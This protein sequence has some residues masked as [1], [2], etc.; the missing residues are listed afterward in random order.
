MEKKINGTS[1]SVI[2]T[3]SVGENGIRTEVIF[4]VQGKRIMQFSAC[5]CL[6]LSIYVAL[7]FKDVSG[8]KCTKTVN[9]FPEER[10]IL[11][12]SISPKSK[13]CDLKMSH[14]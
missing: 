10:F 3:I 14:F 5:V 13:W 7:D 6:F 8:C 4:L 2:W 12:W 1:S 9:I 11:L